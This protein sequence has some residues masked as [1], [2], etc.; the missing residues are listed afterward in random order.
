MSHSTKHYS[1]Q[2]QL[3]ANLCSS[4]LCVHTTHGGAPH[5]A[6]IKV[7][8]LLLDSSAASHCTTS[9]CAR[10][11]AA[12]VAASAVAGRLV[13]QHP[14]A[15]L[16]C[17]TLHLLGAHPLLLLGRGVLLGIVPQRNVYCVCVCGGWTAASAAAAAAS[18]ASQQNNGTQ[19]EHARDTTVSAMLS[20]CV[21]CNCWCVDQPGNLLTAASFTPRSACCCYTGSLSGRTLNKCPHHTTPRTCEEQHHDRSN[22]AQDDGHGVAELLLLQHC[23]R[24]LV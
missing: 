9:S 2:Q 21:N 7:L 16:E 6:Q 5:D 17:L 1:S 19:V 18:G 8:P 10:F 14:D 13:S 22:N 24:A 11:A 3:H 23:G 15:L 20:C 12:T 4:C